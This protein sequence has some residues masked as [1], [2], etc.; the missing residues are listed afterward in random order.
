[1]LLVPHSVSLGSIELNKDFLSCHIALRNPSQP[2]ELITV[3]GIYII[4]VEEPNSLNTF[5]VISP[6]GQSSPDVSVAFGTSRYNSSTKNVPTPSE[7]TWILIMPLHKKKCCK[8]FKCY[9][10][11]KWR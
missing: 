3:N 6:P 10:K 7:S 9:E 4:Q 1:M 5:H 11:D 8:P 2:K